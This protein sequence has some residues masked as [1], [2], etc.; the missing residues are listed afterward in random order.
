MSNT[1]QPPKPELSAA[2]A[3]RL[4]VRPEGAG[5]REIRFLLEE[6]DERIGKALGVSV[7]SHGALIAAIALIAYLLPEQVYEPFVPQP[8]PDRIVWL[9]EPGPGG[10][11]GGGGNES[12]APPRPVELPGREQISVP[13][14]PP[15]EPQPTPQPEPEPE[16]EPEINIPARTMAAASQV[17]PGALESLDASTNV[18]QGLGVGGGGGTGDGTGS[19]EGQG[20]GLGAGIGG[21]AGG[22]VFL[23]GSGVT[24]PSVLRQVRPAYTAEAMRAKV[25]GTVLLDCVVLP[26]GTVGNVQVVRSLDPTF[27]LDEEA[28]KAA[29][30]WQF[31]PG[32][33]MGEP[34]AVLVRIEL[35][36]TLR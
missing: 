15:P 2:A 20:S 19:G 26:D 11:G 3:R 17:T 35:T 29:R 10:G 32:L 25:Q 30:Q 31:A 8:L 36:F 12:P 24:S 6:R 27:G 34:V 7:L 21:G 1:G 13:V 16:P 23:P 9:A 4:S 22:G 18:S 28:I 14:T 5:P 33:R